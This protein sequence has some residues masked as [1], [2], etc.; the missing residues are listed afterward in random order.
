MGTWGAGTF[1]ND[2]A[3][4]FSAE[5]EEVDREEGLELIAGAIDDVLAEE[6]YLDSDFAVSA[7]VACEAIARLA[8][9]GGEL[10]AYSEA[11]DGWV[12][13]CPGRIDSDLTRRALQAIDR[14]MGPDSELPEL[15]EGDPD[16]LAAMD[17]LKRRV[18]LALG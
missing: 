6:D 2:S 8:G 4:D 10:S 18:T 5:F 15:W 7:V 9:Q 1:D 13:R 11:L 12:E 17:D 3:A 14:I 16:W